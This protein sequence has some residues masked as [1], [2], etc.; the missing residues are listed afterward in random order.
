MMCELKWEAMDLGNRHNCCKVF[1]KLSASHLPARPRQTPRCGQSSLESCEAEGSCEVKAARTAAWSRVGM[2]G[3]GLW[4]V[5]AARAVLPCVGA[6][7]RSPGCG[8]RSS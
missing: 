5:C 7:E 3:K 6:L 4:H 1:L 2:G 8:A